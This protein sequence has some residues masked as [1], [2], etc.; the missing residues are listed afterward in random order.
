MASRKNQEQQIE[1]SSTAKSPQIK[2]WRDHRLIY[3]DLDDAA[4]LHL[5]L[6]PPERHRENDEHQ[7]SPD[8]SRATRIPTP[9]YGHR[10]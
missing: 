5:W 10:A 3:G 2:I 7:Q 1:A 9:N 8:P 6:W 4:Q